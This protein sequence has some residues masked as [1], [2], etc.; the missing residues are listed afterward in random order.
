M[1]VRSGYDGFAS[2]HC[3][4]QCAGYGLGL[5]E[6]GCNVDIGGADDLD[7][8]IAKLIATPE[9][10]SECTQRIREHARPFGYS[11]VEYLLGHGA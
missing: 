3:V 8:F 9:F 4:G 1:P 2:A 5:I 10:R 7:G 6:I 11:D